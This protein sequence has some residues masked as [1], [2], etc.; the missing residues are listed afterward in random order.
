M[1]KT[2]RALLSCFA[3]TAPA[4]LAELSLWQICLRTK[5]LCNPCAGRSSS[6]CSWPSAL[7]TRLVI[8]GPGGGGCAARTG[9]GIISVRAFHDCGSR[10]SSCLTPRLLAPLQPRDA[11]SMEISTALCVLGQRELERPRGAEGPRPRSWQRLCGAASA[12]ALPSDFMCLGLAAVPTGS[13]GAFPPECPRA[14]LA[15]S[16]D[17]EGKVCPLVP[18]SGELWMSLSDTGRPDVT[19]GTCGLVADFGSSLYECL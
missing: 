4:T 14:A 12:L 5:I 8:P 17:N 3:I 19:P 13:G 15:C 18:R 1:V 10:N 11:A 6:S 9:A 2:R 7:L 16:R